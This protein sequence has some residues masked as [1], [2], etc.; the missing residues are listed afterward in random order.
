MGGAVSTQNIDLEALRAEFTAHGQ[1]HVFAFWDRLGQDEREA[2]S[3]QCAALDLEALLAAVER[4]RKAASGPASKL[5]PARVERHPDAGGDA[6]AHAEATARGEALL[7]EGRVAC[8]VVAGGQ[9]TRLGSPGPK[10]LF[11]IGPIG[12][13][14]LFEIQAQKLRRVRARYDVAMPWYVM[15]SPATYAPTRAAF[16]EHGYF[17][18]PEKDVFF[19]SQG[20]VPSFDFEG[21]LILAEPGR[22]AENPD[23][24]GGV[25]PALAASGALADMRTSGLSTW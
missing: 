25:I 11:P 24:H 1:A 21:R 9:A 4:T 17:G 15:T 14:C 8:L 12:E 22:L 16:A 6:A 18:L 23:G 2:L 3:A 7:R 5:A 13:R 20:M 19:F 10:G